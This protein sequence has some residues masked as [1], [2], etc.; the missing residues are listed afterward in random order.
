VDPDSKRLPPRRRGRSGARAGRAGEGLHVSVSDG[1]GRPAR[2][3][4]LARWLA[5]AVPAR[6]RGEVGIALVTDARIRTLNQQYRRKNTPTDVLSFP[7]DD[8][9]AGNREPRGANG[10]SR[11][12][13]RKPRIASVGSRVPDP[14]SR[15]PH[16]GS[17]QGGYLGDIVIA[18][19][20]ARR[21]AREAGHSYATELRVLALHGLLHLLGYDHD[22]AADRGRMARVETRLRGSSGLSAGLIERSR[23]AAGT[24]VPAGRTRLRKVRR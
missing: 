17:R 15:N 16:P 13:S 2:D 8:A 11:A 5:G 6:W 19:G 22:S 14:G 21:Q 23:A 12:A 10:A 7:A 20:V 3:G 1:R 24:R 18:T 4:D 9:E